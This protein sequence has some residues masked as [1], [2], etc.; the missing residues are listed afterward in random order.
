MIEPSGADDFDEL[1]EEI[2]NEQLAELIAAG[3][4]LP[5]EEPEDD[6]A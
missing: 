4:P 3:E 5:D 2:A 6:D 1:L